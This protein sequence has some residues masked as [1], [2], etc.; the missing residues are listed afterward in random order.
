[1]TMTQVFPSATLGISTDAATVS[2]RLLA[3]VVLIRSGRGSGSGVIWQPDGLIVTNNHVVHSSNVEVVLYDGTELAGTL[4]A[5]DSARDLAALQV[6]AAGLPAA[7]VG[8]SAHLHVGQF[9]L[10]VGN[11]LGLRSVVTAGIITS[12]GQVVAGTG[13]R[14]D[15]LIQADVSLAPGNSGGPLADVNGRVLGINSMISAAGIALAVPVAAVKA[16]LAPHRPNRPY[17]GISG[18]TVTIVA[19][20]GRRGGLLLTGVDEGSPADRA[21][22]MQG[23]V[24]VGLDGA[25]VQGDDEVHLWMGGWHSGTPV[26]IDVVR[27]PEPRKFVVVPSIQAA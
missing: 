9:V 6:E 5:R 7:E 12:V 4:I 18:T 14:L 27:G 20:G 24:V 1:M 25:T 11:P 10:A 17:L 2:E 23:D 8:D 16:F 15:D 26:E 3:S 22:L 21:G 13:I 19:A